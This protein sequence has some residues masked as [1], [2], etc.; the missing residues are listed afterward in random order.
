MDRSL[1]MDLGQLQNLLQSLTSQSTQTSSPPST[2]PTL[3][4]SNQ[5]Y[6]NSSS[7]PCLYSN[8]AWSYQS[9]SNTL[10]PPPPTTHHN[11]SAGLQLTPLF[12]QPS[13]PPPNAQTKDI[14]ALLNAL[15]PVRPAQ[16]FPEQQLPPTPGLGISHLPEP[17]SI[18]TPLSRQ[19]EE[20]DEECSRS[21]P[22]SKKPKLASPPPTPTSAREGTPELSFGT[23]TSV[24]EL[25]QGPPSRRSSSAND[26][27]LHP[28]GSIIS[29]DR[30]I[31]DISDSP[32]PPPPAPT[33]LNSITESIAPL[34]PITQDPTQMKFSQ[35]LPILTRL[36]ESDTFLDA[37]Q[38]IK[39]KQEEF[40]LRLLDER[41]RVKSEGER[42]IRQAQSNGKSA[43]EIQE[44]Q[45]TLN[46][47]LDK[48]DQSALSRWDGLKAQQQLS[49]QNF[50]NWVKKN[51]G[52]LGVPTFCL[53]TDSTVVK[54]QRQVLEI[55][56]SALNDRETTSV[57]D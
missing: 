15:Q 2:D 3:V 20:P 21:I 27:D 38:E 35:A 28:S 25:G 31:I 5:S 52:E 44:Y 19:R 8:Q 17:L 10:Y 9:Q 41:N 12:P 7:H 23:H 45:Q 37:F 11:S 36:I 32:P 29:T 48:F 34:S 14:F 49:L 22:S 39:E 1:N 42:S 47:E 56:L 6:P 43:H 54:R 13:P 30:I 46:L 55:I 33:T 26:D 24:V 40:E 57:N 4:Q 16:Y 51:I 53:T 50:L 18:L